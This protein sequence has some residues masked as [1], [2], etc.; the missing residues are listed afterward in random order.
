MTLQPIRIAVVKS[1]GGWHNK[2]AQALKAQARNNDFIDYAI[3]DFNRHDWIEKAELFDLIIWHSGYMG[4]KASSYYKEKIFFLENYMG[5]LVVPNYSTIWHFESKVAQSYIF[6]YFDI[7]VPNTYV[8][9]SYSDALESLSKLNLPLVFKKSFGA[10]SSNVRLVRKRKL[11]IRL[12][13]RIFCQQMWD[14]A[15][16]R[17]KSSISLIMANINKHWFWAKVLQKILG[18]ER[19]NVAYWQEFIPENPADLRIN[20]IGD[21]YALGFWRRNRPNDFRASGSGRIDYQTE[22][23]EQAIRYCL[24]I[25]RKMNFDSMAYDLLFTKNDKVVVEMSYSYVDF[26]V[27]KIGNYFEMLPD[28]KLMKRDGNVWPQELWIEW[29]LSRAKTKYT[30]SKIEMGNT[31]L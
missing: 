26:Y 9:F 22:I 1:V 19:Y 14:D 11:A 6:K 29:A 31:V 7:E 28:G 20:V 13:Q 15:K 25:N 10:S 3:V 4:P 2:F 17:Y 18:E 12:L 21:R 27:H 16:C 5:K 24:G 8:T 23:P 30:P